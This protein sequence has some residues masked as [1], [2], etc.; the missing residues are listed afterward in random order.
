MQT[1]DKV[2]FHNRFFILG[3]CT[4]VALQDVIFRSRKWEKLFLPMIT[5]YKS[6]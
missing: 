2:R 6:R 1:H 4:L 5:S 3:N